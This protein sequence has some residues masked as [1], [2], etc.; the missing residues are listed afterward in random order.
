MSGSSSVTFVSESR[1]PCSSSTS[2]PIL[3]WLRS[4]SLVTRSCS[5]K[6][7]TSS[8]PKVVAP[9]ISA[10]PVV[11]NCHAAFLR[12]GGENAGSLGRR[13]AVDYSPSGQAPRDVSQILTVTPMRWSSRDGSGAQHRDRSDLGAG[14]PHQACA[15]EQERAAHA[16][17]KR[18]QGQSHLERRR[19]NGADTQLPNQGVRGATPGLCASRPIERM[20]A[21]ELAE[22]APVDRDLI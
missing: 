14:R 16:G 7:A 18:R 11:I 15:R 19:R 12:L 5:A 20:L 8:G 21:I 10:P 3:S 4:T 17:E 6:A 1:R 13:R 22:V 2:M 9:A